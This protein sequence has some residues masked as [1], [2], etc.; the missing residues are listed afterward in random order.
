MESLA[1]AVDRLVI[2]RK[3][4]ETNRRRTSRHAE[5]MNDN[6]HEVNPEQ[7]EN[8]LSQQSQDSEK[9]KKKKNENENENENEE[10]QEEQEEEQEEEERTNGK[11]D[12]NEYLHCL[13]CKREVF[14]DITNTVRY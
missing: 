1:Q 8:P 9:K 5:E 2:Q 11:T 3:G 12:S 4:P 13:S 6:L 14:S 10:E 7:E